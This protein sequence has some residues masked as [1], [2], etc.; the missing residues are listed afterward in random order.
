[1][2]RFQIIGDDDGVVPVDSVE[3]RGEFIPL[4]QT[5]NCHTNLFSDDEYDLALPILK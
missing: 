5:H 4:G 1:M 2:W 3:E